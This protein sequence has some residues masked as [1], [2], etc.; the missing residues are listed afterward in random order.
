M[1]D[2][3]KLISTTI[4]DMQIHTSLMD[5]DKNKVFVVLGHLMMKDGSPGEETTRRLC[6]AVEYSNNVACSLCIVNGWQYRKDV[7]ITLADSM[8]RSLRLMS[9]TLSGLTRIQDLSR[10]TVGDAVFSKMLVDSLIG[11]DLYEIEIF[12]SSYH[13]ERCL[14]IFGFVYGS[15]PAIRFHGCKIATTAE[16]NRKEMDSLNSFRT[17]FK[18][19]RPGYITDIYQRMRDRHPLYNGV[20]HPKICRM[21]ESMEHLSKT[22]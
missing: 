17:T 9:P 15:I 7:G 21:D 18:G 11:Y 19:L 8:K 13:Q 10:D 14:E 3:H 5:A 22:L 6:K 2:G 16:L 20:I 12:S 1:H 4:S